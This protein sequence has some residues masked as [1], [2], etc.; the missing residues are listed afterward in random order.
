MQRGLAFNLACWYAWVL[1]TPLKVQNRRYLKLGRRKT[2][3]QRSGK[4]FLCGSIYGKSGMTKHLSVCK[5]RYLL[6]LPEMV[7]PEEYFHIVVEGRYNPE[8][9]L[10]LLVQSEATLNQLDQFL[11]DI[12]LECCDHLSQFVIHG[13]RYVNETG[14]DLF[15]F[16]S[17]ETDMNISLAEVL[18]PGAIFYHEYDFGNTTELALRVLSIDHLDRGIKNAINKVKKDDESLD[19]EGI[20]VL[21]RNEPPLIKC[22]KCGATATL[23][24]VNCFYSGEGWFCQKCAV[25][26]ECGEEMFLPVVNSP[27]VGRCAYTGR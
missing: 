25:E 16:F 19:Y 26:H 14:E 5:K 27:R 7:V 10:H 18:E 6:S 13:I 2:K 12:W 21:A 20:Y 22:K 1:T 8:Y 24:C 23:V 17:N 3:P 9:W 11:R 4:C 15:G